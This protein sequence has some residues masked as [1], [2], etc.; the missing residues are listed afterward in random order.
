MGLSADDLAIL[1][2]SFEGSEWTELVLSI[3]G[4]QVALTKEVS[5]GT[6]EATPRKS[7]RDVVS[8]SV[9]I[10]RRGPEPDAPPFAEVGDRVEPDQLIAVVQV[11]KL[12]VKRSPRTK[13]G[14]AAKSKL[15]SEGL[16]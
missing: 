1:L 16:S 7:A 3:G 11:L 4:T 5:A 12:V 6:T 9:G 14:Q 13:L 2:D 8:P 15:R 10:F